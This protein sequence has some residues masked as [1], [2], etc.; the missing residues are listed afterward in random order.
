M[1]PAFVYALHS[2]QLYGTER[3][4]LHTLDGLRD[5]L[6]P[7]LFAPPGP[8]H[9]AAQHLGIATV[10]FTGIGQFAWRLRPWLAAHPRLIFAATGVAHSL[11][12]GLWNRL[13]RRRHLHLHLVHG[14]ADDQLSYG[15]KRLL[16]GRAVRFVA[17]SDYVR[18][19]LLAHGV[20]AEQI[21]VIGNFLPQAQ[22]DHA[23]RRPAFAATGIRR[24]AIVSRLD[25]IKRVGLLLDMLD[26]HPQFADLTINVFGTGGELATLRARAAAR[27]P[28]VHLQGYSADVAAALADHDLLL[29]LCPVEPF[30]LAILEAMAARLPVLVAD[31]GGAAGLV[32]PAAGSGF[33]FRADDADDLARQLAQIRQ[34][35]AADLNRVADCAFEC[36]NARYAS[37]SGLRVYRNLFAEVLDV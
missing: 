29:H 16:N 4:A 36:L 17:V 31:Q 26:R 12:F 9:E 2:G 30:G 7:V 10:S 25:P 37:T 13:Y 18:T 8:V 1:K 33:H 20:R 5:E 23:P 11:V 24:I 3:M 27:H 6:T 19:R 32:D 34:L 22:I 15:R 28:N 35:P 21:T 14:G